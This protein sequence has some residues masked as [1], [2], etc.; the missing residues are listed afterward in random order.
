MIRIDVAEVE[1][2]RPVFAPKPANQPVI[3]ET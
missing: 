3:K 1:H 2:S